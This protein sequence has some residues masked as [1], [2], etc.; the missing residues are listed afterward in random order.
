MDMFL[1]ILALYTICTY[2][3]SLP[4]VLGVFFMM[5]YDRGT[6]RILFWNDKQLYIMYYRLVLL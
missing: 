2:L 3:I 4:L 5:M 1:T 6:P